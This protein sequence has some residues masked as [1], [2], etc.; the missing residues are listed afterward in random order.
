M[1]EQEFRISEELL[2]KVKAESKDTHSHKIGNTEF[3][4]FHL[5]DKPNAAALEILLKAQKDLVDR[6]WDLFH[7]S[8]NIS[9]KLDIVGSCL[10]SVNMTYE[11]NMRT[12]R[13][14]HS[15]MWAGNDLGT[16]G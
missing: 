8:T 15:T 7:K 11:N 13:Q 6:A 3:I 16:E 10:Y 9:D 14:W 12:L 1:S 4:H 2:L 5:E